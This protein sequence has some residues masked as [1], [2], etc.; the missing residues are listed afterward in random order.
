VTERREVAG[1]GDAVELMVR[2]VLE[3]GGA[4]FFVVS[5]GEL[6]GWAVRKDER[7]AISTALE[8]LSAE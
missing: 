1:R 2:R 5:G 3:I 6:D 4:R 7:H 8:T